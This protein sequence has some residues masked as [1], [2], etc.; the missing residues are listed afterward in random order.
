MIRW[1]KASHLDMSQHMLL[2]AGEFLQHQLLLREILNA[3]WNV[4]SFQGTLEPGSSL[5]IG[6]SFNCQPMEAGTA[7]TLYMKRRLVRPLPRVTATGK[8]GKEVDGAL[9]NSW[10]HLS[11]WYSFHHLSRLFR[12]FKELHFWKYLSQGKYMCQF[13]NC[14]GSSKRWGECLMLI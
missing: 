13:P 12:S 11:S 3:G 5:D 8:G 14:V 9:G 2:E 10:S 7:Q 6:S 1:N 4:A